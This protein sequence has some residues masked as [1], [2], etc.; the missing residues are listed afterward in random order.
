MKKVTMVK[1]V[2]ATLFALLLCVSCSNHYDDS[3]TNEKDQYTITFNAAGGTGMMAAQ[4]I[5][6]GETVALSANAYTRTYYTFAGWAT[7]SGS[8]TVAYT[9][10]ANYT[11]GNA[12]VALY[13]VWTANTTGS[14]TLETLDA[15]GY[16]A[17][18]AIP[19]VSAGAYTQAT[20]AS[21]GFVHSI[22]PF[23]MG[24]YEVTYELWYTVYQWA[25]SRPTDTYTF[26]N[27]GREGNDG[28]IGAAPTAAKLEP[29]TTVSWRDCIVW[30]NAYSEMSGKPCVY[31]GDAGYTTP[32]R[33][34]ADGSYGSSINTAAGSHDN[35]CVNPGAKGY[36]LPTEGEWQYAASCA[37]TYP[38]DY[39]SG[40]DTKSDATTGGSDVDGDGDVQYSGD[41]AWYSA[42]NS[43]IGTKVVGTRSANKFGLCDLSGNVYE[44]CNDWYNPTVP[45]TAQTDYTGPAYDSAYPSRVLRGGTW[46]SGTLGFRVGNRLSGAPYTKDICYG[47]RVCCGR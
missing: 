19:A 31:Y 39:A 28:T 9:D 1:N 25:I 15:G 24:K 34:S 4:T 12:N 44:W 47:F 35:P 10:T 7:S 30:C 11:M 2:F 32:I 38:Y 13:A 8:T 14:A 18:T 22:S 20:S 45:T 42:N 36:R 41:V 33:S 16:T 26:A 27:A 46:N 29:V 43:P 37:A 23:A 5:P 40:A 6:P 21:S 3:S 17:M